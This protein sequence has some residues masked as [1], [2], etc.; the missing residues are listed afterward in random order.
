MYELLM[1]Y[2]IIVLLYYCVI[3]LL[4]YCIIVYDVFYYFFCEKEKREKIDR[5]DIK[6]KNKE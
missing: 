5:R 1:C 2:C 4:C 6:K 3:V